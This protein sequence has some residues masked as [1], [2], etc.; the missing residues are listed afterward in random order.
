VGGETFTW[1]YNQYAIMA[2]RESGRGVGEVSKIGSSSE[3]LSQPESTGHSY[4]GT[5][6][7]FQNRTSEDPPLRSP[8]LYSQ[9]EHFR[10]R[11]HQ[12]GRYVSVPIASEAISVGQMRWNTTDGWRFSLVRDGIRYIVV[13]SDTETPS[14]VIVTAW[15]EIIDREKALNSSH[16]CEDDIYTIEV[17]SELSNHHSEEIP[18]LIRS[19]VVSRPFEICGH[20]VVTELGCG[21]VECV[22]CGSRFRSKQDLSECYCNG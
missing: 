15:T 18:D 22:D 12:Q 11:L 19:C 14:P 17:R 2:T 5:T 4:S 10:E 21:S 20:S 6:T 1:V 8:S 7:D 16:L 13:V 3:Q 9:T